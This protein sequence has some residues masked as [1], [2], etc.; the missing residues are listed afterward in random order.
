MA[1]Y[2]TIDNSGNVRYL[3]A[4]NTEE[5]TNKELSKAS[6][7]SELTGEKTFLTFADVKEYFEED[8]GD[9]KDV[10]EFLRDAWE[11]IA[12]LAPVKE[13]N[14]AIAK[15]RKIMKRNNWKYYNDFNIDELKEELIAEYKNK[16]VPEWL[17]CR[18]CEGLED[19]A[20]YVRV[21]Y[22]DLY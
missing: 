21:D 18:G 6:Y 15:V 11:W 8:M 14:E 20:E 12:P 17:T 16:P 2:W 4:K 1:I 13:S 9:F 19:I 5:M 7:F 3:A 10:F 22:F